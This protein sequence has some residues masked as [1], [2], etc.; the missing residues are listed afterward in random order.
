MKGGKI[1]TENGGGRGAT[2]L[3]EVWVERGW[4]EREVVRGRKNDKDRTVGS[5]CRCLQRQG[6]MGKGIGGSNLVTSK[7]LRTLT[8]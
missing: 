7:Y 6:G 4:E 1:C 2:K 5:E 3:L 8:L